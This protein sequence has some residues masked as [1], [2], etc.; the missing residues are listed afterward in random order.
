MLIYRQGGS[1]TSTAK[2]ARMIE[3][4]GPDHRARE[5]LLYCGAT[6]TARWT[7]KRIQVQNF[8]R[9]TI[10]DFNSDKAINVALKEGRAGLVKLYGEQ[11][12]MNALVSVI[13]GMLIA[14]P[15]CKLFCADFAAIEARVAFWLAEHEE[16][17]QAFLEKRKLYEEM[18]SEAFGIPI[19]EV[20]KESLERFV[21]KESVLGCQYGLG[22]AKFL[23][24]CHMKGVKQVTPE[25]AKK[26]VYTYRK[27]HHPIPEFWDKIERA[28]L[29][30]TMNPGKRFKATK[31]TVYVA[32]RWLN[33]KLPS[34][35]RL[36]YF[37]P[38][39][40]QKQLA[41]GQMVP[42]LRY[43]AMDLH[44]WKEIPSWGGTLTNHCVQGIARDLMANAMI[45]I[46]NAG[47]QFLL[48]VHDEGLSEQKNGLGSV[49]HYV[50]LMT[51]LPEWAE[52]CPVEAEGWTGPRYKKG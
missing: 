26:A 36:R 40:T 9:P 18:A 48:S 2:Y 10:K 22:W 35:R 37:K 30:A 3:A 42:E 1:K 20:T 23:K 14:S 4:V 25:M 38:R 28:C 46:E 24:N 29:Q 44:Q 19:E 33:I 47:Y 6:P 13:R 12:V 31:V 21:G 7:G 5:I 17:V 34:G 51:K 16:G 52:G 49:A 15:G 32:D 8:A 41:N 11:N 27:V 43:F 45:N 50:S 39:V